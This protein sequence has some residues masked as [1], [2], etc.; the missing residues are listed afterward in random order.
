LIRAWHSTDGTVTSERSTNTPTIA[1]SGHNSSYSMLLKCTG[2]DSSIAAAQGLNFRYTI[3]GTDFAYLY[4][5]QIT[6]SFWCK[7]ASANTGDTYCIAFRNSAYNR[8]Y[9]TDFTATS[10]WTKITKTI[11]LDTSGTWLFTEADIGM[12]VEIGLAMGS[13]Y[14][15]TADSWEGANDMGTSSTSN[16]MDSTS[17]EFYISQLQLVLGASSPTFLGES[18]ATV[19]NQVSYYVERW[20]LNTGND[21]MFAVGLSLATNSIDVPFH[22]ETQKRAVPTITSS[23]A[24]T[25]EG[26]DGAVV[27][28][29]AINFYTP[30]VYGVQWRFTEAGTSFVAGN[31]GIIQRDDTDTTFIMVDARH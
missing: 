15:G 1:E 31:A 8:S 10:S 5:Q 19:R 6:I 30:T 28:G 9:V 29:S 26:T 27:V 2:T 7:T 16:F 13:D 11:T 22:Y 17:N 23:A 20:D 4:Q 18:V 14:Q 21:E 25:W 24:A 12:R 3:T